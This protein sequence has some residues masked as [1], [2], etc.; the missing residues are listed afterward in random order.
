MST[1][2]SDELMALGYIAGHKL[3]RVVGSGSYGVAIHA[4]SVRESGAAPKRPRS[5][6]D[7]AGPSEASPP[8]PGV[9]IKVAKRPLGSGVD[10]VWAAHSGEWAALVA[11][12]AV[13]GAPAA[14]AAGVLSLPIQADPT[15]PAPSG[16]P[17]PPGAHVFPHRAHA[18][19]TMARLGTDLW[20]VMGRAGGPSAWRVAVFAPLAEA[21]LAAVAVPHAAGLVHRD[22]KPENMCLGKAGVAGGAAEAGQ[23]RPK[24]GA[25]HSA[26]VVL[27][28]Y[29]GAVVPGRRI[30]SR[31]RL[32]YGTPMYASLAS[33]RGCPPRPWDDLEALGYW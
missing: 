28:D 8:S 32:F 31:D 11:V 30:R 6:A 18:F 23:R 14:L 10:S 15:P 13:P 2:F 3:V 16:H 17:L 24:Q 1:R 21:M 25:A 33:L 20:K 22:V 12:E 4:L 26:R 29:G 9:V 5:E 19:M 7:A 27:I